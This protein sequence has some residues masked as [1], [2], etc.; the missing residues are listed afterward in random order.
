[1]LLT[2]PPRL[3]MMLA[4]SLALT[5]F[6]IHQVSAASLSPVELQILGQSIAFLQPP[7]HTDGTVAIVYS[8]ADMN[9][10]RDAEAI[11][12]SLDQ[13]RVMAAMLRRPKLVEAG[14]LSATAFDLIIVAAGANSQAVMSAAQQRHALCV[15]GDVSS[16]RAGTCVM[17]I[18]SA[19]RVDILL[20]LQAAKDAGIAFANA[21]RMMVQ[22]L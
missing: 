10:Q 11:F 1:M 14:S 8:A 3:M 22:E 16:V 4:A 19:K 6:A 2:E 12:A 20:N 15:T 13:N 17:A 7:L 9:S 5:A 21:F 18:R